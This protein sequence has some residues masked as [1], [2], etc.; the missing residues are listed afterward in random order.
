MVSKTPPRDEVESIE[1]WG[2][3]KNSVGV[4]LICPPGN[5]LYPATKAAGADPVMADDCWQVH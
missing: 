5:I 2:G 4:E 1:D 3:G